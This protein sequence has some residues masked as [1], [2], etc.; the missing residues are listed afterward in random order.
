MFWLPN[1]YQKNKTENTNEKYCSSKRRDSSSERQVECEKGGKSK[2]WKLLFRCSSVIGAGMFEFEAKWAWWWKTI[3]RW[4]V[5]IKIFV[6][7]FDGKKNMVGCNGDVKSKLAVVEPLFFFWWTEISFDR[8]Q[9]HQS[10]VMFLSRL[11]LT[12]TQLVLSFEMWTFQIPI[13]S[14]YRLREHRTLKYFCCFSTD[15]THTELCISFCWTIFHNINQP[16]NEQRWALKNESHSL[17]LC[18]SKRNANVKTWNFKMENI[19]NFIN[20]LGS[21]L[22][23]KWT[24]ANALVSGSLVALYISVSH[25]HII[26]TAVTDSRR[27]CQCDKFFTTLLKTPRILVPWV[28]F[29][30]K[31]LFR[32]LSVILR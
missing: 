25:V 28:G 11:R 31:I 26:E 19:Q 1:N 17:I 13:G 10:V 8:N 15:E 27:C 30:L 32:W 4:W 12:I 20:H 2:S 21:K 29:L 14:S 6:I 3:N 16:D 23:W 18:Q 7:I 5:V 24:W 22:E 9:I